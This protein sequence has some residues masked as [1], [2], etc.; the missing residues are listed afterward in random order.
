MQDDGCPG[1]TGSMESY[2]LNT[3][4]DE[5]LSYVDDKVGKNGCICI[6]EENTMFKCRWMKT[7]YSYEEVMT[8]TSPFIKYKSKQSHHIKHF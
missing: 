5:L 4:N 1:I 7:T 2:V 3:G 8:K 6:N